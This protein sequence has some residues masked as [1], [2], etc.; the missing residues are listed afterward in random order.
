MPQTYITQEE[1][2]SELSLVDYE[3]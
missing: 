1:C 3:T 2:R